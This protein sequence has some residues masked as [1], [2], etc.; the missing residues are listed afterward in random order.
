MKF[1]VVL[2]PFAFHQ[3]ATIWLRVKNRQQVTDASDQ[4]E[5]LLRTGAHRIG[6]LRPDGLRAFILSPL[7]YT[8]SVTQEDQL[9]T[10][11]SIRHLPT[12]KK[13]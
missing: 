13:S 4:I 6:R 2:T 1:T 8:Y 11:V 9:V 5:S 12:P 3:L 10:V 7:V